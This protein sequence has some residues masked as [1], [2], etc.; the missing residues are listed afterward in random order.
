MQRKL[1]FKQRSEEEEIKESGLNID[2]DEIAKKGKMSKEEGLIAK[3]FGIYGS[4]QPGTHMARVVIP[5]GEMTSSQVRVVARVAELYAQGRVSLTTRQC[6]QLHM[7]KT[8]SLPDMM[9]G[10]AE[11]GLTTFHGCGDVNRNVVACPLAQ[12]CRYRRINVLP[13]A[14]E[15]SRDLAGMRDLDNLPRKFKIALSGCGA[16]CAQPFINCIGINAV[17]RKGADGN[18]ETGFRVIIGGG[19]GWEAFLGQEILSFVPKN[20]ISAV[21]RES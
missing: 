10:L 21:C 11:D 13:Y 20:K 4:R 14:K 18:D 1:E 15:I 7:L 17:Q 19:Q 6:V 2:F 16:G 8:P 3:W 12:T 5:G 9:R